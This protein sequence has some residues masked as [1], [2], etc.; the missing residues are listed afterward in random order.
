VAAAVAQK[1]LVVVKAHFAKEDEFVFPPLGLLDQIEAGEIPAESIR[2]AAIEMVQRTK[3]AKNDLEQ[4]H[5]QIF[6][7]TDELAQLTTRTD[8][9]ALRSFA[10]DLSAHALQETE[11]LQ[12]TTIMIG[13][14]LQAKA[15]PA[16]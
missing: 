10:S 14:W 4:E 15:S 8:E 9:P 3:A 13:E 7:L 16:H 1:L 5:V 2:K 6:S 12:P 11:I